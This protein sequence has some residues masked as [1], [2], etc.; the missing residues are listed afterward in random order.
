MNRYKS[1]ITRA[2][3]FALLAT[4]VA[5]LLPNMGPPTTPLFDIGL[6]KFIHLGTY[7]VLAAVPALFFNPG[8]PLVRSILLVAAMSFGIEMAQDMVPGRLFSWGDVIANMLGVILGAVIG[9]YS[10]RFEI[11]YS[12]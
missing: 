1:Q 8:A 11:V 9:L 5:S 2:W 3:W 4:T 7:L 6:D 10:R 12:R